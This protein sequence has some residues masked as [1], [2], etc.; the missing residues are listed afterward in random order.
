MTVQIS[1]STIFGIGLQSAFETVQALDAN[2]KYYAFTGLGYAPQQPIANLPQEGGASIMTRAA[3]KSGMWGAGPANLVPRLDGNIGDLLFAVLGQDTVTASATLAAASGETGSNLHEFTF[4]TDEEDLPYLTV[5]RRLPHPTD[6][7]GEIIK[8]NRIGSLEMSFPAV[9]PIT[10]SMDILGRDVTFTQNPTWVAP[11]YDDDDSFAI[12]IDPN[13]TVTVNGEELPATG[14]VVTINNN[15]VQPDQMRVTGSYVP[16][17]Y[18]CVGRA[19]SVR[20]TTFVESYDLYSKIFTGVAIGASMPWSP[21]VLKG[22]VNITAYSPL[23]YGTAPDEYQYGIQFRNGALGTENNVAWSMQPPNI[24]PGQPI[25]LTL[26]G[27]LLRRA[28]GAPFAIRYQ[29]D[30]ATEY[31]RPAA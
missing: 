12:M 21:Q 15:L 23:K 7:L 17:D 27:T 13:S 20:V 6:K 30:L 18:P 22:N 16:K 29:N 1:T 28:G 24:Q 31:Q 14:A 26:I 11:T 9:G 5:R 19:A 8:D 10:A 25:M 4:A 2:F 3:Y